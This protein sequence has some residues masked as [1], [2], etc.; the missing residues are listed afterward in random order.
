MADSKPQVTND[1]VIS[2]VESIIYKTQREIKPYIFKRLENA[3]PKIPAKKIART[4][5]ITSGKG[6]VGKTNIVANLAICLGQA[7]RKVIILDADLGLANI[8]V[9]F[10]IR[11]KRTLV[12]VIKNNLSMEEVL[13]PGPFGIKI[14]AGGSGILEL[15]QLS[16]E[17]F[18]RLLDQMRFLEGIA[19][20]LLID[21]Q[22]GISQN[23]V[24][25]CQAADQVIVVTNPEPTALA[26]AYGIIKIISRSNQLANVWVLVNQAT[27]EQEAGF[28]F[29]RLNNVAVD[30]LQFPLRNLGY[31]PFDRHVFQ[32]VCK[33]VPFMLFAPLCPAALGIKKVV[34][35]A[36]NETVAQ[37]EPGGIEGFM[38]K[39]SG[40]FSRGA[41]TSP[42]EE[43]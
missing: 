40:F 10:G 1:P 36:F 24:S 6:G 34:S 39:L 15:A 12:D 8:D 38:K 9:V 41:D 19:D 20:Y 7:G 11:P 4:I 21:T 35:E 33:Q 5:T 22:A 18:R 14:I 29:D 17:H 28:I 30:F 25:F 37:V 43:S 16:L 23:V 32:A 3:S 31:I 42:G 13:L 26:D 2:P 27:Q